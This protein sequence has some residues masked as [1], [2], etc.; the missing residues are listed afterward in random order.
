[1]FTFYDPSGNAL[2]QGPVQ[3]DFSAAFRGYFPATGSGSAFQMRVSFPFSGGSA[4][5]EPLALLQV[6]DGAL[7][8]ELNTSQCG[9]V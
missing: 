1:M 9:K 8:A 3:A 6:R 4:A 2:A 7:Q 5:Q